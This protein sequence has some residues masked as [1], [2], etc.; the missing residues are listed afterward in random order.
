[1]ELVLNS[2]GCEL[3]STTETTHST[4]DPP[5][6]I[7]TLFTHM[8]LLYKKFQQY[9]YQYWHQISDRNYTIKPFH[10]ICHNCQIP[11]SHQKIY[12]KHWQQLLQKIC[13]QNILLPQY[14]HRN[15]QPPSKETFLPYTQLI[16]L[17]IIPDTIHHTTVW[18]DGTYN[19]Q[20]AKSAVYHSSQAQICFRTKGLQTV[21]NAEAQA[22]DCALQML[23]IKGNATIVSDSQSVITQVNSVLKTLQQH[24]APLTHSHTQLLR[25]INFT[26]DKHHKYM[27]YAG[28]IKSIIF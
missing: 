27:K 10:T 16:T 12:E 15:Y 14:Q 20:T 1:M 5:E 25:H 18:T 4:T 3:I 11:I 24:N 8:R 19:H 21:F 23:P 13:N 2:L 22:I 28:V 17:P 9:H 6:I 26:L 7:D